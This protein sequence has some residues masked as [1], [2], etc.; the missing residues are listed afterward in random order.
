[1]A[2]FDIGETI[3]CTATVKDASGNLH[4]P[5]TSMKITI[6]DVQNGIEVNDVAMTPDS[7]GIYYYDWHTA[8]TNFPGA[9]TIL[10]KATDGTRITIQ[11][12]TLELR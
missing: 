5:V 1:M 2:N 10:Y 8:I 7:T 12:D 11:R 9:Y 6:T 4:D 3:I